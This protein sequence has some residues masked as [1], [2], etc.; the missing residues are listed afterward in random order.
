MFRPWLL[1]ALLALPAASQAADIDPF[2]DYSGAQLFGRFCASCHGS[3]GFGDGPVASSLKVMIPDL[4]ELS[5]RSGGRFPDE[6]VREM[7][8]GRAV[9]PAHGTR[10]MPVWGY[11]LEAQAGAGDTP[12]DHPR[13]TAQTL[14]DR[15][16]DHLR[17]M[18]R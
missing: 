4:T 15:L 7:I 14:I 16:V 6:R 5:K 18:Q 2:A 9:L 17:S 13:D 8:D 3:L 12:S 1:V 10:P 11:E